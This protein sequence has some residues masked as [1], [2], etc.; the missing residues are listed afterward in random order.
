MIIKGT[1]IG[2]AAPFFIFFKR[3]TNSYVLYNTQISVFPFFL[4]KGQQTKKVIFYEWKSN[5]R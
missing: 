1:A 2:V 4:K 5:M 3:E